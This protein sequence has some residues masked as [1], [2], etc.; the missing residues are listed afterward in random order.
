MTQK[1]RILLDKIILLCTSVPVR[2][3]W[4]PLAPISIN[5][6][7][8]EHRTSFLIGREGAL[9]DPAGDGPRKTLSF[10]TPN[11]RGRIHMKVKMDFIIKLTFFL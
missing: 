6:L 3:I 2:G 9:L 1:M 5:E 4:F 11:S 10:L 8:T 7:D